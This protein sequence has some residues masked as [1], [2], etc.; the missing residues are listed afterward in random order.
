MR[1]GSYNPTTQEVIPN[2]VAM[3]ERTASRVWMMNFQVSRFVLIIVWMI[4]G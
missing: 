2:E 4:K 3:A 1:W